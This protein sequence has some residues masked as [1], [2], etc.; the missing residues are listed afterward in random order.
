[1]SA[2]NAFA[3]SGCVF[4]CKGGFVMGEGL[5]QGDGCPLPGLALHGGP[6]AGLQRRP[7]P[8]SPTHPVLH[9][10]LTG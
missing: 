3:L 6:G 10:A 1:M 9:P 5:Q 4:I 8:A 7:E 2:A